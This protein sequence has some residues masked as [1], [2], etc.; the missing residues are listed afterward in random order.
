MKEYKKGSEF[1]VLLGDIQL[2]EAAEARIEAR[3][4]S[5]VMDELVS[6]KPNPDDPDRPHRGPFGPHGPFGGP[7]VVIPPI[8]WKGWILYKNVLQQ[9]RVKEIQEQFSNGMF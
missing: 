1:H 8:H 6:Y 5:V 3:I 9:E 7:V 2:S 4:Q